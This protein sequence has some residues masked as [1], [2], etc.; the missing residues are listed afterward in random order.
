VFAAMPGRVRARV[1]VAMAKEFFRA[2][3]YP[4]EVTRREWFT[5]SLNYYLAACFFNA[6]PI[7]QREAGA[8]QT[9]RYIGEVLA[10]GDSVLIYPEGRRD[11]GGAIGEFRPG[12]G[13]IASRLDVPVVP[14][15]ISG[16]DR[17][18]PVGARWPTRS[19]VTVAFGPPLRLR[20][21]DYAALAAQ[22]EDAV[23][24]L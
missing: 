12:I 11:P 24:A 6:F 10:G 5:N 3:F 16:L 13:M 4:T 20:G 1:A 8:R 18:L 7:P 17:V 15:R 23:K 19:P 2:H 22:V 21:D 14:V 9:M